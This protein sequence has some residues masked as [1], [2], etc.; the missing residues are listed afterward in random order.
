[1]KKFNNN[2]RATVKNTLLEM[3]Y[4][5]GTLCEGP[6]DRREHD[7][8]TQDE[9]ENGNPRE[10]RIKTRRRYEALPPEEKKARG[11]RANKR[12]KDER[13]EA[14]ARMTPEERKAQDDKPTG[15]WRI[16]PATGEKLKDTHGNVMDPK[17]YAARD[18]AN[19]I[20]TPSEF[21]DGRTLGQRL[22]GV[23]K[24]QRV[25]EPMTKADLQKR[26]DNSSKDINNPGY[27]NS[28]Y[29]KQQ[30]H[31]E[32]EASNN[33]IIYHRN[34]SKEL[35]S[36]SAEVKRNRESGSNEKIDMSN[37]PTLSRSNAKKEADKKSA[38]IKAQVDQEVAAY[39]ASPKGKEEAEMYKRE[40]A[41]ITAAGS[42]AAREAQV[43]ARLTREASTRISRKLR[44][45]RN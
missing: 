2:Y 37:Y 31:K 5:S 27:D 30:R 18:K 44:T 11:E 28:E 32:W 10:N 43:A 22:A 42:L 29:G 6:G 13:D 19:G 36:Y 3:M 33:E 9:A 17:E 12:R 45:K 40:N 1:M 39:N 7:L 20:K 34:F 15:A 16:D 21:G 24:H 14:R 4:M 38:D 35:K 23:G 25:Y 26:Y 8:L 41:A